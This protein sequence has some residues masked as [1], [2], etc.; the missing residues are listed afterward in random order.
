MVPIRPKTSAVVAART[1]RGPRKVSVE[2]ADRPPLVR[3]A[4]SPSAW[5]T[6]STTGPE[7]PQS[8]QLSR[9]LSEVITRASALP[10]LARD[11]HDPLRADRLLRTTMTWLAIVPSS[12]RAARAA[13]RVSLVTQP[14]L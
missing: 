6:S 12:K 10:L 4:A 14:D 8:W 2:R 11:A 13:T 9:L 5:V 7:A 3:I 1:A